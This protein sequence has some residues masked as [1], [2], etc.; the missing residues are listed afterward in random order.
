MTKFKGF[1]KCIV[2]NWQFECKYVGKI[3]SEPNFVSVV[4]KIGQ[5]LSALNDSLNMFEGK[6][7]ELNSIKNGLKDI[8]ITLI[9]L[10]CVSNI[11]DTNSIVKINNLKGI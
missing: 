8:K 7:N 1:I 4:C 10:Q 2:C 5:K 6:A 9:D 3:E 11:S